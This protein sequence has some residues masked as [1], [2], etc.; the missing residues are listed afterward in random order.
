MKTVMIVHRSFIDV[1]A[2]INVNGHEVLKFVTRFI[3]NVP[4]Y[5]AIS[6]FIIKPNL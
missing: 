4:Y 2:Q 5:C 3:N 6:Y 1:I